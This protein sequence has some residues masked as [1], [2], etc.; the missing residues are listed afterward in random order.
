MEQRSII[1]TVTND[2]GTD[3]RMQRI[4]T[5]MQ[6]QGYNVLLVGRKRKRSEPL[7]ERSFEQYRLN[8]IAEKGAVFYIEYNIRLFFFL[9]FSQCNII[10]AVDA[11]TL[12]AC[13]CAALLKRKKLVFDAH[14]Y[15]TEVPELTGRS[16]VK[17]V[18]QAI[19][20]FG[21]KRASACYTV[22]PALAE[23]FTAR[24]HKPFKVVYNMPERKPVIESAGQQPVILYQGDLNE[25]RGLEA[26]ITAMKGIEA[27]LWIAGDGPLKP[28]LEKQVAKESMEH[29]VTFLG[30]IAPDNLHG[31]TSKAHIGINLLDPV[32]LS[33][34]YSV[35]NKFFDYVQAH[36]PVI[37]AP[38]EE[39]RKLNAQHEVA[40]LCNQN[41]ADIR[42][43][44][45]LLLHDKQ[46]YKKLADNCKLAASQWCWQTQ[47][48][49]LVQ[50]YSGI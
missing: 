11:D 27:L 23:V 9:L 1:F 48:H 42:N 8:C 14:E 38:F 16:G 33:Y 47:E 39:Y 7:A 15:F 17:K 26:M 30:K 13:T 4:C 31:I 46:H 44:V 43:A 37:C 29:K 20:S 21:V 50:I 41:P 18:W 32:S 35:A 22:G 36:V 5:T 2:L 45:N 19:L 49:T 34:Q 40:V 12:L 3:Q 6:K 24:Y 28:R 10:S 25:G